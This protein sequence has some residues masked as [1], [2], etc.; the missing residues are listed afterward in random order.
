M[1]M[2]V[3]VS[4]NLRPD[5][6]RAAPERAG[7]WTIPLLCAGIAILACCLL[8]PAADDNRRLVYERERLKADLEQIQRQIDVNGQFLKSVGDDPTLLERLAQRQM[9]M[10]REG[11]SVLDL[12]DDRPQGDLSPYL[13]LSVPPPQPLAPYRP[14]GGVFSDMCRHPRT[15]L[16]LMGGALLLIACGVILGDAGRGADP[17]Q[18]SG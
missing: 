10:V 17:A 8:I 12:R 13:L 7:A 11:T 2:T 3:E 15:R 14:I 18:G 1:T 4:D 9:K 16:F 6:T 5:A